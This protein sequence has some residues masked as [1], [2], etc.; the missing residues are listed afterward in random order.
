[1]ASTELPHLLLPHIERCPA[2]PRS[3]RLPISWSV[4]GPASSPKPR[5]IYSDRINDSASK[6]S[7]NR[8]RKRERKD[9][10]T[11][12]HLA[13]GQDVRCLESRLVGDAARISVSF[14]LVVE[15]KVR[16]WDIQILG[17]NVDGTPPLRRLGQ[18]WAFVSSFGFDPCPRYP[19][20]EVAF[21][22]VRLEGLADGDHA[23][24]KPTSK[25]PCD[26]RN[27]SN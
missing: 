14:V 21:D 23:K 9:V 2:I 13:K 15:P 1:M 11:S 20:P 22:D 8:R 26:G 25:K 17:Q 24:P 19:E 7:W 4:H 5:A 6:K 18:G 16:A 12:N 10:L 3:H 27:A